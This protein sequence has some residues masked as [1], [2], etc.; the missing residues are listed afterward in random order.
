MIRPFNGLLICLVGLL[1]LLSGCTRTVSPRVITPSF[2]Y[3]RTT[4]P[5]T[6]ADRELTDSLNVG[7]LYM[8]FFDIDWDPAAHDARP[9]APLTPAESG[10]ESLEVVPTVFITNRTFSEVSGTAVDRLADRILVKVFAMAPTVTSA[11]IAEVQMDCDWTEST[12]E[13]YFR[14]LAALKRLRPFLRVTATIRLH[15]WAYQKQTGIPPVDGGVLMFYNMGN[16]E[17]PTGPGSILDVDIGSQ[18]LEQASDYPLHLD[19]ALPLFRWGVVL[20]EGKVVHLVHD[21]NNAD[22]SPDRMEETSRPATFRVRKSHYLQGVYVYRNDIVRVEEPTL[23][24]LMESARLLSKSFQTSDLR[25]VFY[26]LDPSLRERY[27]N[28]DLRGILACFR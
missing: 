3:W 17:H 5:L 6:I 24:Q 2:Y 18:Y 22:I 19:V 25:V 28:E 16:L 7:R 9:L 8:R 4:L 20:R 23:A 11:P 1:M 15:Q 12:R 27:T 14:L 26:H 21:L 10:P 13:N